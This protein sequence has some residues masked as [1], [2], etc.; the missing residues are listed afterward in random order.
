MAWAP[1]RCWW[2]PPRAAHMHAPSSSRSE[3]WP[4][5]AAASG[6]PR[7]LVKRSIFCC[8]VNSSQRDNSA[9][10]HRWYSS[11]VPVCAGVIECLDL[12]EGDGADGRPKAQIDEVDEA[13]PRD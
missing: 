9:K 1:R 8:V 7:P 3:G 5:A 2:M 12:A 6:W 13:R 4:G 10:K 11:T